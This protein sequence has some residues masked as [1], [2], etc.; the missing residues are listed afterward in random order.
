MGR[1][2]TGRK[3]KHHLSI[4]IGDYH[5]LGLEK[6]KEIYKSKKNTIENAIEYL[7]SENGIIIDET[8]L[9]DSDHE[10]IP[11]KIEDDKAEQTDII[12]EQTDIIAEQTDIIAEQTDII[13]EQTDKSNEK[14]IVTLKPSRVSRS[15]MMGG[16]SS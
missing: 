14:G 3:D 9:Q 10:Y 11:T 15:E 8:E 2:A 4:Y 13:A 6:L 16:N 12:A 7:L 1:R 5:N